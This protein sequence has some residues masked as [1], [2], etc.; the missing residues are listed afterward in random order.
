MAPAEAES[1]RDRILFLLKTR[2]GQTA[3]NL[4]GRLELTP[5]AIR[6]HLGGLS[7]RGLVDYEEEVRGVG[8]PARTWR[9]TDEGQRRFPQ[10][11]ADLALDI[12]GGVR[13][14]FGNEGL[15]RLLEART[16]QHLAAYRK[17]VPAGAPLAKRVAALVRIRS[18]EGYMAEW[19]RS[20][21]GSLMLIENHCPICAAAGECQSLCRGELELF[22]ALLGKG[23]SIE[24]TEH[25]LEGARRCAYRIQEAAG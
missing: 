5:V 2:G 1:T 14:A 12:L 8:R 17:E 22:R 25:I 24:R 3:T 9:L 20:R 4:A 11:Y 15:D 21:D 18:R 10:G 19:R 7:K 6:Q 13:E 23:V 16:R